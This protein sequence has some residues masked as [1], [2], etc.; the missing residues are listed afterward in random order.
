M[1]FDRALWVHVVVLVGVSLLVAHDSHAQML[2]PPP[3]QRVEPTPERRA[4][5]VKLVRQDCGSCHGLTLK[6]GLGPALLPE[7]LAGK[8]DDALVFTVMRGRPGTAMPGW[9]RFINDSEAEWIVARLKSGFPPVAQ[10]LDAT[11]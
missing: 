11:Q 2:A 3:A 1:L 10:S 8:P 9:S 7:T 5:L 6:G 4:A